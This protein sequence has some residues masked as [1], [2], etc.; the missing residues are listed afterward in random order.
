MLLW[1]LYSFLYVCFFHDFYH[2]QWHINALYSVRGKS[3]QTAL[4]DF[5]SYP[6]WLISASTSQLIMWTYKIFMLTCQLF[7]WI[8]KKKKNYCVLVTLTGSPCQFNIWNVDKYNFFWRVN[9]KIRKVNIME[10]EICHPI[11]KYMYKWS[12]LKN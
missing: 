8:Y 2:K 11:S 3:R 4:V 7:M 10:G 9:I 6:S 12:N 1:H 5:I